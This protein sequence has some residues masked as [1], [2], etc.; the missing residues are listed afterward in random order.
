M[1]MTEMQAAQALLDTEWETTISDRTTD[2]PKPTIVLQ[3]NVSQ[4]DLKT[5]PYARIVDGGGKTFEPRGFGW[6][7]QRIEADV[8]VE[9]RTADRRVDG[10]ATQDGHEE[11]F[12]ARS[13]TG[14]PDRYVGLTGETRRILEANRK[15][16]AEF[17]N[18]YSSEIRNESSAEGKNYYRADVDIRFV[19]EADQ[20]NPAP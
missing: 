12:G 14:E 16:F 5:E 7:H 2:V 18:V 17:C 20:I 9:L 3:Q 10:G 6:T 4:S 13:G 19:Q 15:G 11:M 1:S 8:T